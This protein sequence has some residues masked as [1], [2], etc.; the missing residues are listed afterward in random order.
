[1]LGLATNPIPIKAAMQM[2][3]RD[4]GELRMPLTRLTPAEEEKLR[5][6]IQEKGSQLKEPVGD[7]WADVAAALKTWDGIYYDWD[8]LEQGSA[9]ST[10]LFGIART[11]VRLADESA[12]PNAERL[13]EYRESN[14]E[15]LKFEL[16]SEAPIY[17]DLETILLADSLSRLVEMKGPGDP[18][19]KDVLAGKSPRDRTAELINNRSS[20]IQHRKVAGQKPD[21]RQSKDPMIQLQLVD[22]PARPAKT[23]EEQIEEPCARRTQT[24]ERG[25]AITGRRS[26]GRHVHAA[27][28]PRT[29]QGLHGAGQADPAVDD[30]CRPLRARPGAGQPAAVRAARALDQAEEQAQPQDAVQLRLHGGHHRRQLRQP[31]RQP[32]RRVRRHHL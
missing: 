15:S 21:D 30:L 19:V 16:F 4:T 6:A 3:G 32:Q 27:A 24:G 29:G 20:R 5:Q 10:R 1:M 18:L 31:R 25:F 2:L 23:Y 12:R 14:L 11:L 8:L 22:G 9:F 28:G 17:E 7:P 26:I 13:R